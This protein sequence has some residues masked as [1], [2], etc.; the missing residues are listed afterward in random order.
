MSKPTKFKAIEVAT[1]HELLF[2][3]YFNIDNDGELYRTSFD[4]E[5]EAVAVEFIGH[6]DKNG[7]E[8]FED[9]IAI[10]YFTT[11]FPRGQQQATGRV[12]FERGCF[13][14]DDSPVHLYD[15]LEVIGNI[16]SNPDLLSPTKEDI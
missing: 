9:D 15:E 16:Y 11:S 4:E 5:R 7:V 14:L 2:T 13:R 6:L 3:A 8:V 12:V 1:G 10:G